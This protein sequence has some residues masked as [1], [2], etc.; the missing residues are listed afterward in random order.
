MQL[1]VAGLLPGGFVDCKRIADFRVAAREP[2]ERDWIPIDVV[3]LVHSQ[4]PEDVLL[5]ELRHRLP[6]HALDDD[7]EQEVAA[8]AV[9]VTRAGLEI[10]R[11]LACERRQCLIGRRAAGNAAAL[12][13]KEAYVIAEPAGVMQ[14]LPQRHAL[15]ARRKFRHMAQQ[16]IIERQLALLL[17]HQQHECRELL[18]DGS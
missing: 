7:A 14:Q 13:A 15:R 16:R 10:R 17:Q 6:A 5:R 2:G 18:G 9:F 11:P 4:R 12:Q 8:I 3:G 1:P